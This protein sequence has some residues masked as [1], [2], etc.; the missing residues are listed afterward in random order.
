MV[1]S[2]IV[3]ILV[4]VDIFLLFGSPLLI[5]V[6]VVAPFV[7]EFRRV[8]PG[9]FC[10]SRCSSRIYQAGVG[11]ATRELSTLAVSQ[12]QKVRVLCGCR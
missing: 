9:R 4:F 11:G 10:C 3:G 5:V 12:V 7:L 2:T 8:A 6:V 1:T